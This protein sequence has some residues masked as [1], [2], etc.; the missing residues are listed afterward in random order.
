MEAHMHEVALAMVLASG[1]GGP[2][3]VLIALVVVIV[4]LA[5]GWISY[6]ARVRTSRPK[7][8]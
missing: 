3:P 7:K 8:S 4:L 6:A 1:K 5:V 2:H